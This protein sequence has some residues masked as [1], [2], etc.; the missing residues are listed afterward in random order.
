MEQSNTET[1]LNMTV[2][3]SQPGPEIVVTVMMTL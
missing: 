1:N 3:Y 2:T